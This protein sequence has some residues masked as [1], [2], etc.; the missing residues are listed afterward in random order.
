MM[1]RRATFK[2]RAL[3]VAAGIAAAFAL[4]CEPTMP[5][6]PGEV[7]VSNVCVVIPPDAGS[8]DAGTVAPSGGPACDAG[9]AC[10]TR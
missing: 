4:G 3:I 7:L 2:E 8:P 1:T 6:D 9:I 5:C 10:E